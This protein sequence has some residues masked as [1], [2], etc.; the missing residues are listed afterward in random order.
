[1][2]DRREFLRTNTEGIL[3]LCTELVKVQERAPPQAKKTPLS[4]A[5]ENSKNFE[6][7]FTNF[8]LPRR[9]LE[10]EQCLSQP[11]QHQPFPNEDA[12]NTGEWC[13][14]NQLPRWKKVVILQFE[15]SE[16]KVVHLKTA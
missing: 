4:T 6:K 1:M 15:N 14:D 12:R 3:A 7:R 8:P 13:N 11:Q 2:F 16:E 9:P 5:F 10:D